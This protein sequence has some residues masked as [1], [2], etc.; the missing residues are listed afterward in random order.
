MT[1]TMAFSTGQSFNGGDWLFRDSEPAGIFSPERLSDEHRLI[2]QTVVDFVDNEVLPSLER[3][4]QKDWAQA[5]ALVT[6]CGA[7]GLLGVDV[8]ES[9]GGLALDKISSM[10]DS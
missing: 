9:D 7:L 4:E 8:S 3:L 1:A 6:R 5:R 2:G 10:P